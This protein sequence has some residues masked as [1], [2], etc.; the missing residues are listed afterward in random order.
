MFL[1][2]IRATWLAHLFLIQRPA[3]VS[4]YHTRYMTCSSFLI[5]QPAYVSCY[6]ARYMTC[7]SFLIQRPS[8]VSCYH[9]SYMICSTFLMHLPTHALNKIQFMTHIKLL[10]ISVQGA[11]H[12]VRV[13]VDMSIVRTRTVWARYNVRLHVFITL[14]TLNTMKRKV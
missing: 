3:Y 7:S 2:T 6:H 10:H 4:C 1:V 13:S 5:Q 9:A 12:E 8:N 14:T 11:C